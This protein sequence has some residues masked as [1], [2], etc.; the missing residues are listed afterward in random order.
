MRINSLIYRDNYQ[1]WQ[2][3]KVDFFDLTLLVGG[4]GVGKTQILK[5]ILKLKTIAN[6]GNLSFKLLSNSESLNGIVWKINFSNGHKDYIWEGELT[7]VNVEVWEGSNNEIYAPTISTERLLLNDKLV[8][9][10]RANR[11][12]FEGKKMPK[13]SLQESGMS[14]FK[15]E[16]KVKDAYNGFKKIILRDHTAKLSVADFPTHKKIIQQYNTLKKIRN[17]HLP[18]ELKLICLQENQIDVFKDIK[19]NFIDVF[20]TIENVKLEIK[21]FDGDYFLPEIFIK[22]KNVKSWIPQNRISSGMLRTFLHISEMKLLVDGSV[23][24]IDEFENSLG[25]NCI[26][27]LTED[28]IFENNRLQFIATSH[29]PYII[30]K[31]PYQYWKIV[32]RNGGVIKTHNTQEF[33]LDENYSHHE[34]FMSLIN[35]PEYREGLAAL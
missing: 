31:I 18:I 22:Q 4:S 21:K 12:Y 29:H 17:S 10:R 27:I 24:L 30:N 11:V 13:L 28:L 9:E 23:I 34:R 32:T 5:A 3:E 33:N 16:E 7:L 19:E 20:P 14:I 8:F 15:E 6:G 25:V 2:I 1:E 26:D 35:L